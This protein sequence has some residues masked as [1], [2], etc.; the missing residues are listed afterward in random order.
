MWCDDI[1]MFSYHTCLRVQA[2]KIYSGNVEWRGGG[3]ELK[4]EVDQSRLQEGDHGKLK[5]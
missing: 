5:H 4:V 3:T 1:F 2:E